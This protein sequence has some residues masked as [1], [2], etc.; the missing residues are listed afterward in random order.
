MNAEDTRISLRC[1]SKHLNWFPSF[2]RPLWKYTRLILNIITTFK[3]GSIQQRKRTQMMAW[4]N[5][6]LISA[7]VC[8]VVSPAGRDTARWIFQCDI[9][10]YL[11]FSEKMNVLWLLPSDHTSGAIVNVM[12]KTFIRYRRS[13]DAYF[14]RGAATSAASASRRLA[15]WDLYYFIFF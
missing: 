7:W 1:L 12:L 6:N 15:V 4:L 14:G 8:H 2:F 13:Q 9:T 3:P 11:L 5:N 10:A